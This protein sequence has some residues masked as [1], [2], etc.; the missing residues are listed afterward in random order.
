MYFVK[1]MCFVFIT[2]SLRYSGNLPYLVMPGVAGGA[3]LLQCTINSI[4]DRLLST[5][6]IC[7]F[8]IVLFIHISF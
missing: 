5:F 3:A 1:C 8:K 7:T 4:S 6:H 2:V